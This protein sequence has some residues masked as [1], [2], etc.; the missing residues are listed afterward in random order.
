MYD[1]KLSG[2]PGRVIST[3]E[4]AGIDSGSDYESYI[5]AQDGNS[6]V[7]TIDEVIQ[8]YVEK[9]L[10]NARVSNKLEEGAAAI[11]MDVKSGD[12]LAMATKPDYDLNS[13]FEITQPILDKYPN[14]EEDLKKL[15][16]TEYLTKF[17]EIIQVVRRNKAVVDSYEPGS[18]FKA[19]VASTAIETG[20][21][22]LDD[23]FNCGGSLKVLTETIHCANRSGHGS[24]KFAEAVQN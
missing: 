17:N 2:V 16:G 22:T 6:V 12:V 7:L 8:S 20:A 18:T 11:V 3:R 23:V 4:T 21:C 13:P 10:E 24:Q 9:H 5:E 14:A 1:D 15:D 19:V